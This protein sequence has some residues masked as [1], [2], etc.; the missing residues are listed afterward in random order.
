[1]IVPWVYREQ[2]LIVQTGNPKNIFSLEDL[3]RQD[4]RYINR[5]RGAGTRI[6]LDYYLEKIGIDNSLVEGYEQE[7]FTHLNVAAAI[8]SRRADTGLGITGAARALDLDFIPLFHER[9]DLIV[10]EKIFKSE[11]FQ[12]ILEAMKDDNFRTRVQSLDGYD[13]SCMGSELIQ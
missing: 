6:L 12:P 1:M 10:P 4:V 11:I 13:I 8:K 9:Y 7:E 3:L 2:G 5:Q